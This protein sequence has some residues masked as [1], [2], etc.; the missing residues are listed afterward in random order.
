MTKISNLRTLKLRMILYILSGIIILIL[1]LIYIFQEKLIFY[2]EKIPTEYQYQ[3]DN[4]FVE[5]TYK[6]DKK[7]TLNAILFRTDSSKGLVFYLH[8]NA[9]NLIS[10]GQIDI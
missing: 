9:G 3:F 6:I 8:G 5:I 1:T 2:P 7:T 4:D 10:W